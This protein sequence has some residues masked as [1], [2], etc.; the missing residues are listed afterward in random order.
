MS[1]H[2]AVRPFN[3][4]W[5]RPRPIS[6]SRMHAHAR[7]LLTNVRIIPWKWAKVL[8]VFVLHLERTERYLSDQ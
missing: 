5:P 8:E 6:P 3:A 2:A 7:F 4:S 1:A